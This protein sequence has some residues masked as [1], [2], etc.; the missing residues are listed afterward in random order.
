MNHE[1][2]SKYQCLRFII[3]VLAD[4]FVP[5]ELNYIILHILNCLTPLLLKILT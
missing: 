1:N 2:L 3:S 4:K 5:R